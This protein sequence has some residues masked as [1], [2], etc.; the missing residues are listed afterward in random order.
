MSLVHYFFGD[1]VYTYNN[2]LHLVTEESG[3]A[4]QSRLDNEN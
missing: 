4:N 3:I 2:R 1:T